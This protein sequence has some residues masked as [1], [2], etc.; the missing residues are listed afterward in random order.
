MSMSLIVP[1]QFIFDSTHSNENSEKSPSL[2]SSHSS[3]NRRYSQSSVSRSVRLQAGPSID[4]SS[5]LSEDENDLDDDASAK[6]NYRFAPGIIRTRP[7]RHSSL[8]S[9]TTARHINFRPSTRKNDSLVIQAPPPGTAPLPARHMSIQNVGFTSL[10]DNQA[11][12]IASN[13]AKEIRGQTLLHLAARL[14]HDEIMRLLISETSQASMLM[15]K[16]GQTPLLTAIEAGATST[17]TLLME[18]DPRSIIA[19]DVNGSS[20]FHYACEHC[21]D[22]VLN[23][24]IA[25]SKRLNSTSDRITVNDNIYVLLR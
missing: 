8:H 3:T 24:A 13:S 15:N 4:A 11:A 2:R 5:D 22:V 7:S 10:I 18:S 23:R 19:S 17:A 1:H 21:N 16:N 6:E 20:V 9:L 12:V 14:G 25:L